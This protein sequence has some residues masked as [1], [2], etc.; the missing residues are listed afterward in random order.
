MKRYRMPLRE[1]RKRA[2]LTQAQLADRIGIHRDTYSRIESG[3]QYLTEGMQCRIAYAL[4]IPPS[5]QAHA[6]GL[7]G[8]SGHGSDDFT[9]KE[10]GGPT[11]LG[12][13]RATK[14][15]HLRLIER[16]AGRVSR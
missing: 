4:G 2:G 12:S 14:V 7:P 6:F 3:R 10:Q 9:G 5:R 1:Y 13:P 16:P 8:G 11:G 15:P